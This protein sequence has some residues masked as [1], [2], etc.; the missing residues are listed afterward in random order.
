MDP[1]VHLLF[2]ALTQVPAPPAPTDPNPATNRSDRLPFDERLP[3]VTLRREE[4]VAAGE[5]GRAG[6]ADSDAVLGVTV[7]GESRAYPI[8][9]VASNEVVNDDLAGVAIAITW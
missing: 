6:I 2:A 9:V 7:G 3:P 4:F 1:L 5:A 8:A